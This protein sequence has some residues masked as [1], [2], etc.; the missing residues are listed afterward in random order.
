M[1]YD[2]SFVAD[3]EDGRQYTVEKHTEELAA[4]TAEHPG[5]VDDGVQ[6]LRTSD[7]RPVRRLGPGRYEIVDRRGSIRLTS[8]DPN[9]P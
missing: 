9:A 6:R 4:S 1:R 3:G 2:G 8:D 5:R 7:G